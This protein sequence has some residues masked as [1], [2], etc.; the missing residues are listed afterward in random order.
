VALASSSH[1]TPLLFRAPSAMLVNVPADLADEVAAGLAPLKIL[2]VAHVAAACERM[3]ANWPL[4]VVLGP[5][6]KPAELEAIRATALDVSAQLVVLVD[7]PRL[8]RLR[9]ELA[10]A[11]RAAVQMRDASSSRAAG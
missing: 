6:A 2:R 8:E 11:T 7:S 1:I 9:L 3:V 5:R 4:V 10:A